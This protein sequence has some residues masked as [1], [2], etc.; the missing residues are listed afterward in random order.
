MMK[1]SIF[2]ILSAGSIILSALLVSQGAENNDTVDVMTGASP[3]GA[4]SG[5][6]RSRLVPFPAAFYSPETAAGVVMS[7]IYFTYGDED[8]PP[9]KPDVLSAVMLYTWKKQ[10][11]FAASFSDYL[12]DEK[13]LWKTTASFTRFTKNYYGIGPDSRESDE[14][15]FINRK[16][17]ARTSLQYRILTGLSAGAACRFIYLSPENIENNGLLAEKKIPGTGGGHVFGLGI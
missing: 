11:L 10:F 17:E 6:P 12:L 13:L 5:S 4:N 16:Y 3:R 15:K 1:R 2:S 7:F 9:S 14:E 8:P